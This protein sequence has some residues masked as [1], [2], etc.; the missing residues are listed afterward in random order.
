MSS[1]ASEDA[2]M[3]TKTVIAPSVCADGPFPPHTVTWTGV[4][5]HVHPHIQYSGCKLLVYLP[6]E[7]KYIQCPDK[8]NNTLTHTPY[9]GEVRV[10][11]YYFTFLSIVG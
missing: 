6:S 9:S 5:I 11:S 3:C 7:D 10:E 4:L 1:R 2:T 8:Q